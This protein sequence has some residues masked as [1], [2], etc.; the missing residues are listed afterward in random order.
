[1]PAFSKA[2]QA[3]TPFGKNEFLRSTRG[4]RTTSYTLA[5]DTIPAR[6]IDGNPGQKILQPGTVLA[7]ITSGPNSGK[8]GP[9]QGGSGQTSGTKEVQT[10]TA[11]GTWSGGT[12]AL[13]VPATASTP[14]ASTAA[15][16]I[17]SNAATIQAAIDTAIGQVGV[18]TVTG[19]PLSTT[20]V[21]ITYQG[22]ISGN[23]AAFT[24][25]FSLVTGTTP[26]ANV[27][28]TTP[29]VAGATDGR[30]TAAN[31]V[32]L[33][34][35]FVPWETMYHD[36]EVAAVYNGSVVQDWCIE[37]TAAGVEVPLT[38]AVA[39]FMQRGGAAGK[40]VDLNYQ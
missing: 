31:I 33:N 21:V 16:P 22:G 6:T 26:G 20:P 7:K 11:T 28:E 19:G 10:I 40:L 37:L 29:G 24:V 39:A 35:T 18:F 2:V 5:A 30:Q 36:V 32:G 17:A 34:R 38:D 8:V 13:G 27:V 4:L 15:L 23:I 1:M 3:T 9:Y 14:A 12:Y 25:D